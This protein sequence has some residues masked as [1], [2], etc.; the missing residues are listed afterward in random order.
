MKK[1]IK[2][3]IDKEIN[4]YY[5][6][7][8]MADGHVNKC[9]DCCKKETL[10]RETELKKDPI[11]CEQERLR[12]KDKYHRLNYIVRQE[13]LNKLKPYRTNQYSNQHRD[14]KL[15]KDE[16]PHHWDYNYPLDVIILEKRVHR[17]I[18]SY[19]IF[20][21]KTLCFKTVDGRLL[22]TKESH[23]QYIEG[24]IKTILNN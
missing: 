3:G 14:L 20:D 19:L 10:L 12:S 13:E 21:N 9:K 6:H 16:N 11:W 8:G 4:E 17:F 2:C 1:C 5:H 23:V 15:K 24:L 7:P 18:H 22:D